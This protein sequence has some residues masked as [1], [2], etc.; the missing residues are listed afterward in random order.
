MQT[1]HPCTYGLHTHTP[2]CPIARTHAH[3]PLC[4]YG[5]INIYTN[6]MPLM[7][8][9]NNSIMHTPLHAC[10]HLL[11]CTPSCLHTLM[12]SHKYTRVHSCTHTHVCTHPLIH[13]HQHVY[14]LPY[15]HTHTGSHFLQRN[16]THRA[17][18]L[19][20][21][22][23]QKIRSLGS[24][25]TYSPSIQHCQLHSSLFMV[26]DKLTTDRGHQYAEEERWTLC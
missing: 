6:H 14:L 21:P 4:I 25:T 19:L 11:A 7:L 20:T 1:P 12:H 2:I 13:R 10:T 16:Q 26:T 23:S 18:P 9:G 15:T 3:A 5:C 24:I 17:T 22:A 8:H